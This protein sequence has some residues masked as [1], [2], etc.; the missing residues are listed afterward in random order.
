MSTP[1]TLSD[2]WE[3]Y[4]A[5]NIPPGAGPLAIVMMR[6]CWY[7]AA[8]HTLKMTEKGPPAREQFLAEIVLFGRTIGREIELAA[9]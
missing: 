4:A 2:A 7:A 9:R 3:A 6:R 8:A 1:T 5:D